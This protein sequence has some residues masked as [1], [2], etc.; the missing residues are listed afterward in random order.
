MRASPVVNLSEFVSCGYFITKTAVDY[1][2]SAFL[3]DAL[4]TISTCVTEVLPDTWA[5]EWVSDEAESLSRAQGWGITAPEVPRLV[6]WT[7]KAMDSGQLGWPNVF[8]TFD[9]AQSFLHLFPPQ[10]A[11]WNLLGLGLHRDDLERFLKVTQPPPPRPG[12]SPQGE[13]GVRLAALRNEALQSGMIAAYYDVLG[14]DVGGSFHSWLC[15]SLEED[16]S[17]QFNIR[18]SSNG[19]LADYADARKMAAYAVEAKAEP[20]PWFPYLIACYPR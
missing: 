11:D 19:L 17:A 3:P 1:R 5:I 2:K 18:P 12:F 10:V 20:V 9:A 13:V 7:T 4:V 8:L 6:K 15:N 14:L 16:A